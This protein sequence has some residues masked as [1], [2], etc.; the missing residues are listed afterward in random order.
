MTYEEK[1]NRIKKIMGYTMAALNQYPSLILD[2][3]PED[4]WTE[5]CMET[6][7]D[8]SKKKFTYNS[9]GKYVD[10]FKEDYKKLIKTFKK[11]KK[12]SALR[13]ATDDNLDN[14]FILFKGDKKKFSVKMSV[15]DIQSFVDDIAKYIT[16]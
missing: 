7:L 1:E 6:I 8:K 15:E 16:R 13:W 11:F 10:D 9:I 2:V 5:E 14:V 3:G 12:V 4:D